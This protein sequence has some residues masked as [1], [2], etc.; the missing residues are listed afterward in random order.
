MLIMVNACLL[1]P[2]PAPFVLI[3]W[4]SCA[5]SPVSTVT[6]TIL[7]VQSVVVSM[8]CRRER[9]RERVCACVRA[10]MCVAATQCRRVVLGLHLGVGCIAHR[11]APESRTKTS[12]CVCVHVCKETA[13]NEPSYS[14]SMHFLMAGMGGL[15]R[16]LLRSMIC[17]RGEGWG[18]GVADKETTD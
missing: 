15:K 4:R 10:C 1:F 8:S 16:C 12:S 18:R 2:S 17:C 5:A 13:R 11:S 9:E 14:T 6:R 7:E 3:R